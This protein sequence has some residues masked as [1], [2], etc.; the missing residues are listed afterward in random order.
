[1]RQLLPEPAEVDPVAAHAA[2]TRPAPG[3]RPWVALNMVASVDGATAIDGVSGGLGG[4]GDKEVFR[5]LRAIADV[6]LV[7][8]GTVRAEGYGP[9]RTSPELQEARAARGQA[10]FPRIAIVTASLD[11]DPMAPVFAE[12]PEA[13]LVFT[14]SDAP[15]DRMAAL[16]GVADVRRAESA[17]PDLAAVLA[18]IGAAGASVVL[19]E[20]G[21][22]LNGQLLELGLIDE[23][24]LTLAAD[25]VGGGAKRL[26][27]GGAP[28]PTP[29]ALAHVWH[30][31]DDLFL[32]YCRPA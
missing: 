3:H 2:A 25:L 13:P 32:R 1:M 16:A 8:A 11:L 22:S 5:A 20:G 18:E 17:R 30:Q 21:P 24:N 23:V 26:A 31:D 7:A 15:S 10:A 12:A 19:C 4:A 28:L 29:M 6:I 9:P 27:A 14:G